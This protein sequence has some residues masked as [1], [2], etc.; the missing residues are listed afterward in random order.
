[1]STRVDLAIYNRYGELTVTVEVKKKFAASRE[2]AARLRQNILAHGH[3]PSVKYFLLALPDRFFLWKN[4]GPYQ[5]FPDYEVDSSILLGPYFQQLGITAEDL[6]GQSLELLIA[7]WLSDLMY[8]EK[9]PMFLPED[10]KWLVESG[11]Y[12]E[13][14]GGRLAYEVAV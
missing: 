1:M 2:W 8:S 11:L 10:Q 3:L 14:Q 4:E 6:S 5:R 9:T 13:L 12:E 7:S